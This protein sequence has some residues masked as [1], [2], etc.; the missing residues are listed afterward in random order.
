VV[1]DATARSDAA[2]KDHYATSAALNARRNILNYAVAPATP[3]PNVVD[4]LEWPAN[5][6][7]LDIGC[8]N[9]AWTSI[10]ADRTARGHVIGLDFSPGMLD[11]LRARV[12]TVWC[13]QG[14]ANTLPFATGSVDVLLAMWMLY[15]TDRTRAIAECRR[16]VRPGGKMIAATNESSFIPSLDDFLTE[17][18]SEVLG[19]P[20]DEW[21]GTLTFSLET[22]E[23]WFTPHFSNVERIINETPFEIPEAAPILGYLESVRGPAIARHDGQFDYDAFLALVEAEL[24]RRLAGGPIRFDR[25][26][27]VFVATP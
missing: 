23:E 10:A 26:I 15:H 11:E 4:L 20:V 24:E 21:L 2:M 19:H 27:A 5:A 22:G 12:P 14:D 17:A 3:Q 6:T 8:G 16:V 7:V 9:G 13:V 1:D 25:R 18:A